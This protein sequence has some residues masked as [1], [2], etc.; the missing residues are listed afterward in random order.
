MHCEFEVNGIGFEPAH[1]SKIFDTFTRLNSKS[2][3]DGTGLGLS[4][5][6]K[7]VERHY[8]TIEANGKKDQGAVFLITLPVTQPFDGL[9]KV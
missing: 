4:L 8:G 5:A 3:Y 7:I 2:R 1:N 6:K 9:R